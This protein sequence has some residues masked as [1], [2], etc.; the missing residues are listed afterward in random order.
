MMFGLVA[1][2]DVVEEELAANHVSAPVPPYEY[3][4]RVVDHQLR[5]A[6]GRW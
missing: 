4:V 5:S 1:G 3:L 2:V 6:H